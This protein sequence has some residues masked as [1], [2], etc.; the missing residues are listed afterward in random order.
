MSPSCR[1]GALSVNPAVWDDFGPS[2]FCFFDC[3]ESWFTALV[4]NIL[5]LTHKIGFQD[6][7]L[8]YISWMITFIL[9]VFNSVM[10]GIFLETDCC[11]PV[12]DCFLCVRLFNHYQAPLLCHL[13]SSFS[14]CNQHPNR[15]GL[16]IYLR[17]LKKKSFNFLHPIPCVKWP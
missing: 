15:H 14:V 13:E 12:T 4:C 10:A 5:F 6:V 3:R 2:L 1:V 17:Y 16:H 7:I 8:W 9:L 11:I